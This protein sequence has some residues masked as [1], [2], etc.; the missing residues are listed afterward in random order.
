MGYSPWKM[1]GL[2]RKLK[3]PK[4]CE[5]G[6]Y[7]HIRFVK[8]KKTTPKTSPYSKNESIL[9]MAKIVQHAWAIAHAKWSLWVKN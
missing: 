4:R 6:F 9:E 2:G 5:K 1:V 8:C 7:D 3:M